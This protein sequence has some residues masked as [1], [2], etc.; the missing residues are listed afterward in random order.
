MALFA[1]G[2]GLVTASIQVVVRDIEHLIGP[3]L[4]LIF[5]VTPIL[6][7]RKL[8]PESFSFV[9]DLNPVAH[10]VGVIRAGLLQGDLSTA[11]VL[12]PL[13]A[14]ALLMVWLGQL[15]FRRLAESFED[16]M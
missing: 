6:Y 4:L 10:L 15:V 1:Y 16:F 5:Y 13:L 14:A 12:A 8:V 7:P 3:V 2:I 9:L 11:W